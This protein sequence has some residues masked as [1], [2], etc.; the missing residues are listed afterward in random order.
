MIKKFAKFPAMTRALLA[1]RGRVKEGKKG[2][3]F[4]GDVNIQ[5]IWKLFPK[6]KFNFNEF[7]MTVEI[8]VSTKE[9][10]SKLCR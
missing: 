5:I 1:E 8:E 9:E 10:K 3:I 7:F 2:K 4:V 6:E